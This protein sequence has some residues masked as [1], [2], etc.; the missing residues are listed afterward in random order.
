MLRGSADESRGWSDSRGTFWSLAPLRLG[1]HEIGGRRVAGSLYEDAY[2]RETLD[3]RDT[4]TNA[5]EVMLRDIS[6]S[7]R[8]SR[9][10][11]G[12]GNVIEFSRVN[13]SSRPSI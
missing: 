2:K 11:S 4:G 6:E 1:P 8:F 10:L 12:P 5:C 13:R 7:D 9:P 3:I